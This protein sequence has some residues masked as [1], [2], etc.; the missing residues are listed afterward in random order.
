MKGRG[1]LTRNK[2]ERKILFLR[3]KKSHKREQIVR[4]MASTTY[5]LTLSSTYCSNGVTLHNSESCTS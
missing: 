3:N 1:L 2:S 5:R 4:H